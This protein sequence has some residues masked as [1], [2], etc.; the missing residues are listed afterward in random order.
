V[1]GITIH[2]DTAYRFLPRNE[3]ESDKGTNAKYSE[4]ALQ[5]LMTQ[6]QPANAEVCVLHVLEVTLGDY[7][8]QDVFEGAHGA[9]LG[10]AHELV[11]R[12]AKPLKEAGFATKTVVQEGTA[13]DAIV[14]FA[15][16][17][18]PDLIFLG[19]HG[20]RGWKRLTLG[21]VSEAV[22]RH[23]HSSVVIVRTQQH[24]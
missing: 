12:F 20:R 10:F 22:A 18:K 17:Y 15:E 4:A 14:A 24:A 7:Q 21:S 5:A 9:K 16:E 11:E 19:S 13:K 23:V 3:L 1:I 2:S 6:I 8:S